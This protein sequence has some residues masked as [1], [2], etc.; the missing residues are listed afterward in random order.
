MPDAFDP[1]L[2]RFHSHVFGKWNQATP[3]KV[4]EVVTNPS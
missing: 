4:P 1:Y 2:E 3:E